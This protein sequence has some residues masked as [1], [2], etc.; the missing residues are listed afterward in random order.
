MKEKI[1]EI[2]FSPTFM[3]KLKKHHKD[4]QMEVV[5]KIELLKNI[6][7]HQYL[8]V[9]KLNDRLKGSYSF[10][11]DY[12]RRIVFDYLDE[13]TIYILNFSGH[14]IYDK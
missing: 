8:K 14:E 11:V 6:T 3:K 13:N 7:N 12:Q 4:I 5:E 1:Y 9:H 10:S 2:A